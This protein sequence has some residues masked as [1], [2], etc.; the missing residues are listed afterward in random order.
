MECQKCE[1]SDAFCNLNE[2]CHL[3][4]DD[5]GEKNEDCKINIEE[6]APDKKIKGR[7]LGLFIG[8]DSN[9]VLFA[10]YV[11]ISAVYRFVAARLERYFCLFAT[12]CADCG[13]HLA[14]ATAHTATATVAITL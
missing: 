9:S 3:E 11:A 7:E 5:R 4:A 14:R 6:R 12:L 1:S 8:S 2:T 10:L 13:E